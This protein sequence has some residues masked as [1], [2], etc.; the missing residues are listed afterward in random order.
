MI[1]QLISVAIG[2][3]LM[4]APAVLGY[5]DPGR[6]TDRIV[7]PL[8]ASFGCIAV[9][10]VTRPVRWLNL[11]LG[12]GLVLAPWVLGYGWGEL[13]HSTLIGLAVAGLSVVTHT[14]WGPYGGGW[15]VLWRP[16][17]VSGASDGAR[18]VERGESS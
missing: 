6:T 18:S 10:E 9:W 7:G 14:N 1:P 5:G 4:A 13:L 2:I 8:V 12:L 16:A 17:P 11:L 3:W 15:Q